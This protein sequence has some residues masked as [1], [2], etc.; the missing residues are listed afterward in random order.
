MWTH[1]FEKHLGQLALARECARLG[2]RLRTIE[3]LTGLTA[4]TIFCLLRADECTPTR[5]RPPSTPEWYHGGTLL[6]RCEASI[7]VSGYRRLCDLG[8]ESARALPSA[9]RQYLDLC[10]TRPRLSFDRAF[11][12][13]RQLDGIWE[14]AE[15]GLSLQACNTCTCRYLS[16]VGAR[17]LSNCDCP[18]CKL[19]ARY[20]R[21]PRVQS[22]FPSVPLPD[23]SCLEWSLALRARLAELVA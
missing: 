1:P 13:A 2:A 21:D 15:A 5:G 22:T 9:Y 17:S 10:R 14:V 23:L 3:I 11:D 18:F 4:R 7:F 16:V 19:T 12:L 20:F 6:D 8:F